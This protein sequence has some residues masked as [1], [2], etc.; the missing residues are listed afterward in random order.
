MNWNAELM[1]LLGIQHKMENMK[2]NVK[3]MKIKMAM[4]LSQP[5]EILE[6]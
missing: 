2:D 4:S 5:I 3:S 1:L 6:E